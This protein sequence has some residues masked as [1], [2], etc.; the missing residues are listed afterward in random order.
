M[1]AEG[2]SLGCQQGRKRKGIGE[3]K[4]ED[5]SCSLLG[6]T[7]P[8]LPVGVLGAFWTTGMLASHSQRFGF[9]GPGRLG[10]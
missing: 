5:V 10:L 8:G 6:H 3:K 7:Q 1:D 2:Q 4:M 9:N